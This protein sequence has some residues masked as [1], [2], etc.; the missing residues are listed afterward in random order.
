MTLAHQNPKPHHCDPA[1]RLLQNVLWLGFLVAFA[2]PVAAQKQS[3]TSGLLPEG[4][5]TVPIG[6]RWY[7]SAKVES[8]HALYSN[9]ADAESYWGYQHQ[10]TDLMLLGGMKINQNWKWG[11]GY[12]YRVRSASEN[13]HRSIQEI[14]VKQRLA[15]ST[16]GHRLRLDQTFTSKAPWQFRVRYRFDI[17]LPL[18]AQA[19]EPGDFFLYFSDEIL[20]S[21]RN[22]TTDFE[23]RFVATLGHQISD[24]SAVQVGIDYRTDKYLTPGFR[25]RPWLKVGFSVNL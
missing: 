2:V 25:H 19:I 12:L 11:V 10:R 18:K 15:K 8:V 23:N 16:L 24:K 9:P 6:E 20:Y 21:I 1:S 14:S 3:F 7:T 22:K 17:K 13:S 4:A 5:L